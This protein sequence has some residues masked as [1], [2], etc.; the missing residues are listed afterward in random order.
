VAQ[1]VKHFLKKIEYGL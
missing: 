1:I